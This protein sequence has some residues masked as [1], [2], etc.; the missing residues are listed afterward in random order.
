MLFCSSSDLIYSYKDFIDKFD[1]MVIFSPY[2]KLSALK[3]L[4]ENNESK[5]DTIVT[6]W[7]PLDIKIGVSDIEVYNFTKHHNIKLLINNNIHLK[8]LVSYDFNCCTVSSSNITGKGLALSTKYNFELGT[9]VDHLS[10]EEKSY[11]DTI[12]DTSTIVTDDLYNQI[13]TKIESL[14]DNIKKI[15]DEFI[16]KESIEHKFLTSQLP[17]FDNPKLLFNAVTHPEKYSEEERRAAY[18]DIRLYKLEESI[19]ENDIKLKLKREFEKNMFIKSF[20]RYNGDGKFFG[21]LTSWLHSKLQDVP[22]PRRY[23]VKEY[24]KRIYNYVEYLLP[25]MYVIDQPNYSQR[26][27]KVGKDV[28]K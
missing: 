26:L 10:C 12:I 23:L 1:K 19:N 4:L 24:L 16:I 3:Q 13:Y 21:E 25:E 18:H 22:S 15:P 11:F 9:F 17:Y 14:D 20:L 8:S 7:K 5:I 28:R 27:L 6:S 2:I